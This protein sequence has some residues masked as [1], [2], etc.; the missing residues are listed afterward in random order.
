M[1]GDDTGESLPKSGPEGVIGGEKSF[2][3]GLDSIAGDDE[4]EFSLE[5]ML[6]NAGK[7]M[8]SG[9]LFLSVVKDEERGGGKRRWKEDEDTQPL[10]QEMVSP[11]LH[12]HHPHPHHLILQGPL[13]APHLPRQ[14]HRH[15]I[16]H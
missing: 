1:G 14:V 11:L 6:E 10:R 13:G 12:A 2:T 9:D 7:G 16:R 4:F 5:A 3:K 8:K 15:R